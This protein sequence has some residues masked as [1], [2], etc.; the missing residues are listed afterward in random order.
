MIN[1]KDP[2]PQKHGKPYLIFAFLAHY[3]YTIRMHCI[4]IVWNSGSVIIWSTLNLL[5]GKKTWQTATIDKDNFTFSDV[6]SLLKVM[7]KACVLKY[8][9]NSLKYVVSTYL[10][11]YRDF[12]QVLFWSFWTFQVSEK[13]S[14]TKKCQR[15]TMILL[16]I[17]KCQCELKDW[18]LTSIIRTGLPTLGELIDL[19]N[20]VIIFLSQMTLLRSLTFLLGFQTV[21]LTVL[22]FWI[23]FYLL[24]LVFVLQWLSLH[25]ETLIMLLSQF[26]LVSLTLTTRCT[27]SLYCLW[28][29]SFWLGWSLWSFERCSMQ[30]FI[31]A[32]FYSR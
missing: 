7:S 11:G 17:G 25:W 3:F 10:F 23:Y 15:D 20:S 9:W 30:A 26:P 8:L 1:D 13:I 4:E 22:L 12:S 5:D 6:Y 18:T 32:L 21:I 27:I 14:S 31:Q 19:G 29:F 2:Y 16:F 24:M 28:L